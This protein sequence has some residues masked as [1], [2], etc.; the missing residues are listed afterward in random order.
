MAAN[1]G[2]ALLIV[3]ATAVFVVGVSIEKSG[4]EG[5]SGGAEVEGAQVEGGEEGESEGEEASADEAGGA[6]A[7]EEEEALLGIDTEST[8]LIVLAGVASLLLAAAVWLY[9]GVG[10]LLGL[11]AVA[12]LVF[13]ALD[14]R[15]AVAQV[16]ESKAAAAIL[17]AI[18]ALLH[19]GAGIWAFAQSRATAAA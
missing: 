18:V 12:M 3:L 17:A 10:W 5:H 13:A 16:D 19:L 14:I 4:E 2:L 8:G 7:A 1:R 6:E 9:P 15:E 11:V